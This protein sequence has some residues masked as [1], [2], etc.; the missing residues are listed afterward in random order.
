MLKEAGATPMPPPEFADL[1]QQGDGSGWHALLPLDLGRGIV[2]TL[3]DARTDRR[4]FQVFARN[5]QLERSRYYRSL[6]G[7]FGA[8][9]MEHRLVGLANAR[10]RDL[11]VYSW[12]LSHVN[13]ANK[14]T[15][16]A[17]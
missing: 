2:R 11:V 13:D 1:Q 10:V 12:R 4:V 5:G 14:E 7:F 15:E 3:V 16:V 8:D 9:P 6:V 17:K